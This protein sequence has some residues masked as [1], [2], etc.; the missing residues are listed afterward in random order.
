MG[1]KRSGAA[2][3]G[4]AR[5]GAKNEPTS[6]NRGVPDTVASAVNVCAPKESKLQSVGFEPEQRL[7]D[8]KDMW[9]QGLSVKAKSELSA[10]AKKNGDVEDINKLDPSQR[11][12]LAGV[13]RK[14]SY[15]GGRPKVPMLAVSKKS[16]CDG[17]LGG[18]SNDPVIK[19]ILGR[20]MLSMLKGK[21]V[22]P[23]TGESR[24]L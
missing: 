14:I 8:E 6:S 5:Y 19:M 23:Y 11:K 3:N 18:D 21:K 24:S 15:P 13:L 20:G 22:N 17:I 12:A 9:W 1:D 4:S 7:G 2:L 16:I 10:W